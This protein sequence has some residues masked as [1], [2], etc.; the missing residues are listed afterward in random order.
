MELKNLINNMNSD[1]VELDD[2]SIKIES[3][4]IEKKYNTLVSFL[5]ENNIYTTNDLK[6]MTINDYN[7][8]KMSIPNIDGV[9]EEKTNLFIKKIDNIRKN[10]HELVQD[11]DSKYPL[12]ELLGK[13]QTS[14][15]WNVEIN[16]ILYNEND[17]Y[18]DIRQIKNDG[19]RGKGISIKKQDFNNF[20]DIILSINLDSIAESDDVLEEDFV[21]SEDCIVELKEK[22]NKINFKRIFFNKKKKTLKEQILVNEEKIYKVFKDDFGLAIKFFMAKIDSFKEDGD[23]VKFLEN[24]S[25][26]NIKREQ[27]DMIHNAGMETA[28]DI[29]NNFDKSNL[30]YTTIDSLKLNDKVN[31]NTICS[32]VNNFNIMLGMYYDNINKILV[33]K[34]QIKDGPY[35]D[36]W[37]EH[38]KKLYYCLQNEHDE[39][40]LKLNFSKYPNIVCKNILLGDDLETK[41]YLF[42]RYNRSDDYTFFGEVKLEKFV[43]NNKAIIVDIIEY[44]LYY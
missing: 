17:E 22:K 32:I 35:E 5:K 30:K 41:V 13:F 10:K 44:G 14:T 3:V 26:L 18:V 6:K 38:N 20:K 2:Y 27:Y 11:C 23:I 8:L 15:N 42:C 36:R 25:I 43:D 34:C 28:I 16:H 24:P 39:N 37:V 7:K 33:L 29:K 12:V 9:G 31:A 1:C 21:E 40:F 4:I 19:T